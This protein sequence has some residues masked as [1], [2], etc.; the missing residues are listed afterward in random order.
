MNQGEDDIS[1][2]RS[3]IIARLL[4]LRTF[5]FGEERLIQ[6]IAQWNFHGGITNIKCQNSA[7]IVCIGIPK[8]I[9][10][11]PYTDSVPRIWCSDYFN[12][13]IFNINILIGNLT[14]MDQLL[15]GIFWNPYKKTILRLKNCHLDDEFVI[16][17]SNFLH[18][19]RG[20]MTIEKKRN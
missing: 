16:D 7:S 9:R 3:F 18:D 6:E 8:R 2:V 1:P 12:S 19:W 20:L 4:G 14:I 11:T 15:V 13:I 17:S 10:G 5:G